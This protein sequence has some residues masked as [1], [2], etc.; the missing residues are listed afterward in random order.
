MKCSA[1][2]RLASG[3]YQVRGRSRSVLFFSNK[4]HL[5]SMSIFMFE[6]LSLLNTAPYN[7]TVLIVL[8]LTCSA[9]NATCEEIR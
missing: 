6:L 4:Y 8:D 3:A 1:P 9:E 7:W 5:G 2:E